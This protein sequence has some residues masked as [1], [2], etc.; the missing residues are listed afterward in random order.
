[1]V[2]ISFGSTRLRIEEELGRGAF[3]T[4]YRV[5][6]EKSN[7]VYALKDIQCSIS[8]SAVENA[9][10]EV[11]YVLEV[12][13]HENIITIEGAEAFVD[14]DTSKIHCRILTELC[15]LA[16]L[17]EYL[18]EPSIDQLNRKWMKQIADALR[19]LH[20]KRIVHG[21]L[22]PDNVLLTGSHDVKVADFGLARN[23]IALKIEDP[24]NFFA[25]YKRYYMETFAEVRFG[26]LLKYSKATPP[27]KLMCSLFD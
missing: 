17:N 20:K 15:T 6:D 24:S 27:K 1:M 26:W 16:S 14:K 8:R 18:M 19:F 5:R 22:K 21:D 3:G 10:K 11:R 7:D 9:V 25:F 23:Y 2:V 12:V 4:A 13:N